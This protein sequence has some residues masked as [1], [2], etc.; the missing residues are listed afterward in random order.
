MNSKNKK[1][2]PTILSIAACGGVIGTGIFSSY[3]TWRALKETEG[4]E[5]TDRQKLL[6]YLKYGVIPVGL[7]AATIAEILGANFLNKREQA[8]LMSLYAIADQSRKN[9]SEAIAKNP[10]IT[11][12]L[13]HD[14]RP[15]CFDLVRDNE[16][17]FWDPSIPGPNGYMIATMADMVDALHCAN[18]RIDTRGYISLAEYFF[19]ANQECPD[20]FANIGWSKEQLLKVYG[21]EYIEI[22]FQRIILSDGEECMMLVYVTEPEYDFL[23]Y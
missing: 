17:I 6:I 11:S 22:D 23:D 2:M 15:D 14:N 20:D 12:A 3:F 8:T 16:Y 19:F 7:A 4:K 18:R 21:R 13:Y 5:L 10:E 9:L 1:N